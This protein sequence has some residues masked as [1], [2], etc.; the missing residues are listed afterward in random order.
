MTGL[1]LTRRGYVVAV[2]VLV[3][4]AFMVGITH[5]VD[6]SRLVV[7]AFLV[8]LIAWLVGAIITTEPPAEPLRWKDGQ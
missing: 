5:P 3:L 7:P 8:G 2:T 6:P 4:A 1:R